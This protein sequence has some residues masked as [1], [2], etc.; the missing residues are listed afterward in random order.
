MSMYFFVKSYIFILQEVFDGIVSGLIR[1]KE[2]RV[3]L[4]F[5]QTA[6]G[7]AVIKGDKTR[8]FVTN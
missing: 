4:F 2:A 5:T 3:L 8:A 6:E 7:V 1:K